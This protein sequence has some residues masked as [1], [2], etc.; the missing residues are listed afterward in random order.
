MAKCKACDD[1]G[2]IEHEQNGKRV[3]AM[4]STLCECRKA[5]PPSEGQARW[6]TMETAAFQATVDLLPMPD[7]TADVRVRPELPISADNYKLV[8]RGNR[9]YP[10]F[11]DLAIG[12]EDVS[13]NPDSARALGEALIAAANT[14]DA[15]DKPDTDAGCGHWWPCDCAQNR[16][17]P[18]GS[19]PLSDDRGRR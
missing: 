4:W 12:G 2:K 10:T 5:L 13:L 15:I 14:A 9:Y 8:R 19:S 6:W 17:V 18:F 3:S 16:G 11:V 7:D 1:T